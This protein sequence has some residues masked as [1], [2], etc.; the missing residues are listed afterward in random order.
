MEGQTNA[1]ELAI[2]KKAGIN[3]K[4]FQSQH[5]PVIHSSIVRD[6]KQIEFRQ[7]QVK[8][9]RNGQRTGSDSDK[10]IVSNRGECQLFLIS[11][12]LSMRTH[13]V[14]FVS[15]SAHLYLNLYVYVYANAQAGNFD[16][17]I[18]YQKSLKAQ[19]EMEKKRHLENCEGKLS[20]QRQVRV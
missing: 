7:A 16:L 4:L 19:M 1:L 6:D 5:P 9:T 10:R 2:S 8:V 20:D 12:S 11:L 18:R 13:Y 15:I 17:A 3:Q 14:C